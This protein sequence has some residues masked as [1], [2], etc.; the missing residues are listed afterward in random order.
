M[1][2]GFLTLVAVVIL[3]IIVASFVSRPNRT[4]EQQDSS[5]DADV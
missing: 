3:A 4:N 2:I 1:M 5:K